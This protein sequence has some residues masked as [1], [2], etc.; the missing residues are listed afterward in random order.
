MNAA[1]IR[2]FQRAVHLWLLGYLVSALA[3]AEWLWAHPVGPALPVPGPAGLL[4][5]AF[6]TWLPGEAAALAVPLLTGFAAYG[7]WREQ[8]V[9]MA[10]LTWMLF[11]SLVQR[12]WLA[13]CGGLL[14]MDNVL[15]WMVLLRSAPT[16]R[17]ALAAGQLAFH[18]IRV[19][20]AFTYLVTGLHKLGGTCWT[21]GTAVGIVASDPQ[22]GPALL[23]HVPLLS[24][25][26]T[27]ALLA[28]Q[29]IF[30]VAV[31]F[32]RMRLP[33]LSFGVL[34]HLGTALWMGIPEMG[35][36]FIACYSVFL[37]EEE[38]RAIMRPR[39]SLR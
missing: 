12:A 37:G 24:A 31:W 26:I 25:V 30:P 23:V 8:P 11:A 18:A 5:N 19:Q 4:V 39:W 17:L 38:A 22:F 20:V 10:F 35:F 16:G 15:L 21:G 27:W 9:W 7:L 34:F 6:G 3:A 2:L 28:F 33:L 32:R 13:S 1:T 14:L 36:A 29:F